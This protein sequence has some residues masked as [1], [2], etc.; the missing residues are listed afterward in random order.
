MAN[1]ILEMNVSSRVK[2]ILLRSHFH[3]LSN[4]PNGKHYNQICDSF[5]DRLEESSAGV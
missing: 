3:Q 4:H 2:E 1:H 5:N